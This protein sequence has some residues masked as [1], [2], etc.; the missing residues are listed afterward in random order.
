MRRAGRSWR[1]HASN[2][3]GGTRRNPLLASVQDEAQVKPGLAS[4]RDHWLALVVGRY[5]GL[6]ALC[7]PLGNGGHCRTGCLL[8]F[9]QPSRTLFV[10]FY[11]KTDQVE[12]LFTVS[13]LVGQAGGHE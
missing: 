8:Q 10:D 4:V 6:V 11:Q 2:P 5:G 9:Q 7:L 1:A 13:Q 3:Q 12:K